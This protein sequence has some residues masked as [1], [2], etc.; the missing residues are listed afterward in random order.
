MKVYKT[1]ELIECPPLSGHSTT[2]VEEPLSS[3]VHVKKLDMSNSLMFTNF[4]NKVIYVKDSSL[5]VNRIMPVLEK[6]N[7]QVTF[8][9]TEYNSHRQV[10]NC[11]N[12]A[13][14]GSQEL[15]HN[16]KNA[17][18]LAFN[19]ALED[20]LNYSDSSVEGAPEKIIDTHHDIDIEMIEKAENGLHVKGTDIVLFLSA[21]QA[22]ETKH[23]T[24]NGG[25]PDWLKHTGFSIC[26]SVEE[27]Y[28]E[29]FYMNMLGKPVKIKTTQR[30][31]T[32]ELPVEVS[33]MCGKTGGLE[34]NYYSL[35]ELLRPE[36]KDGIRIYKTKQA[37]LD[38]IHV[39]VSEEVRREH[40]R[41]KVKMEKQKKK[42]KKEVQKLKEKQ[43]K[44]KAIIKEEEDKAKLAKRA[45]AAKDR[46]GIAKTGLEAVV[47]S[48]AL[49]GVLGGIVASLSKGISSFAASSIGAGFISSAIGGVMAIASKATSTISNAVTSFL[50]F[51]GL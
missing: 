20:V 5:R 39:D 32:T 9:I 43:V 38:D 18:E 3:G 48:I 45:S 21:R 25:N 16:P 28:T 22:L 27:N 34:Y 31:A 2:L 37:A 36:G 47:A 23:I 8:R 41:N 29:S 4:T 44:H 1:N 50:G 6:E 10:V 42:S 51:I 17:R 26:I 30:T 40:E 7:H 35:E 14:E 13:G 33:K 46:T 49:G 11:V 15:Y 19:L 12:A 24:E